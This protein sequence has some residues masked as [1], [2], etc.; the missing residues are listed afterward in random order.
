MVPLY[1]GFPPYILYSSPQ[2]AVREVNRQLRLVAKWGEA[3]QVGFSPEKTKAMIYHGPQ[4]P[5][6]PFQDACALEASQHVSDLRRMARSLDFQGI[7]TLYKAQIRHCMEYSALSWISS[8]ATHLQRLDAVQPR[9]LRLLERDRQ[10]QEEQTGVTSLGHRRNVSALVVQHK[11][12]VLEVPHLSVLRLP[13]RGVRRE[14]RT[15]TSSDM[16]VQVPRSHSRQHQRSYTTGTA[17]LWN[18]FTAAT[19]DTQTMSTQQV[20]VAAHM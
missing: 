19:S 5:P 18:S 14:T 6:R 1:H 11:D 17:R 4:L 9:A 16:L 2:R 3:W 15:T 12:Q 13:P 8:A 10:Q 7:L 20:K